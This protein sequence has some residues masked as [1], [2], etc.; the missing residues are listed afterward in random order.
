MADIN[1]EK[2]KSRP[3][4]P[5]ILLLLLVGGIIWWVADADTDNPELVEET[6]QV[7][8][9]EALDGLAENDNQMQMQQDD[10]VQQ[11]ITYVEDSSMQMGLDHNATYHAMTLLTAALVEVTEDADLQDVNIQQKVQ[12]IN[13]TARE[14]KQNP[15]SGEHAD[16]LHPAMVTVA[17]LMQ[18]MKTQEFPG[19]DGEAADVM[20]AANN[21]NGKE[22]LLSQ[23]EEVK[24]FFQHSANAIQSIHNGNAS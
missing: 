12:Q 22:L 21:V 9:N 11:F 7:Y 18:E 20:E 16:K 3:I 10:A 15:Y 14:L 4:W 17:N 8:E 2:K 5:W 1:I 19:L 24:S 6:E 23:K 13:Q